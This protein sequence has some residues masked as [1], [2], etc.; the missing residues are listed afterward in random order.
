MLHG[1]LGISGAQPAR[2]G[3]AGG[4]MGATAGTSDRNRAEGG[5]IGGA[6]GPSMAD[7]ARLLHVGAP[8]W[9]CA[10]R[11]MEHKCMDIGSSYPTNTDP[12]S[13]FT[14][15]CGCWSRGVA[16]Q[17]PMVTVNSRYIQRST[18]LCLLLLW[19]CRADH[20]KLC[21]G[22]PKNKAGFHTFFDRPAGSCARQAAACDAV[23]MLTLPC[24]SRHG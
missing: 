10:H 3:D 15:R 7:L 12:W 18:C 14:M 8:I 20:P 1:A 11:M 2:A 23:R 5:G 4:A 19:S 21:M 16:A 17:Q 6:A 13:I 22:P 9:C 24:W